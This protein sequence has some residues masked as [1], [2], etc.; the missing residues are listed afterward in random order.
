M[1]GPL[2]AGLHVN[3]PGFRPPCTPQLRHDG[4]QG[5]VPGKG[6]AASQQPV[7]SGSKRAAKG[8]KAMGV[9]VAIEQASLDSS[10][11]IQRIAVVRAKR[12]VSFRDDDCPR[13]PNHCQPGHE[14]S[15]HARG[16]SSCYA[17]SFKAHFDCFRP[18]HP[19]SAPLPRPLLA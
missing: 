3:L 6:E 11:R 2:G 1:Y 8:H 18:S 17:S 5:L 14:L 19:E 16:G 12:K 13:L 7:E 10:K 4:H 15:N 9:D